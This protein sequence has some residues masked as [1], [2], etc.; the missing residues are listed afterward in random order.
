M[1]ARPPRPNFD[2][3]AMD[4]SSLT[5]DVWTHLWKWAID[6]IA[7]K[8][9]PRGEI[10]LGERITSAEI[11]EYEE[12]FERDLPAN[13][14][15]VLTDFAGEA[16]V[17]FPYPDEDSSQINDWE[18]M[19]S[20]ETIPL[21][22]GDTTVWSFPAMRDE[23]EAFFDYCECYDEEEDELGDIFKT[24]VPIVVIDNGDFVALDT[25]TGNIVYLAEALDLTMMGRRLA[26]S[27]TDYVT[28]MAWAGSLWPDFLPVN[29]LYDHESQLVATDSEFLDRWHGWLGSQE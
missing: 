5:T 3:H 4:A 10:V 7:A 26:I 14:K 12:A 17:R 16:V 19:Q 13:L 18:Q 6:S 27:F 15:T 24:T 28:R 8:G 23:T 21:F 22:G 11:A 9:W 1:S 2:K 29:K 20:N 25:S